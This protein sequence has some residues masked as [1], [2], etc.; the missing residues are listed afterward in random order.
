MTLSVKRA[1]VAALV[2]LV[3]LVGGIVYVKAQ[4]RFGD[5]DSVDYLRQFDA[6]LGTGL[7]ALGRD[8]F[9][10]TVTLE[11]P[12]D[13]PDGERH[14]RVIRHVVSDWA[15]A[16]G[17]GAAV[18]V[19]VNASAAALPRLDDYR[20]GNTTILLLDDLGPAGEHE[21]FGAIAAETSLGANDECLIVFWLIGSA[22]ASE[23]G[24]LIAHELFHCVQIA[25]LS[26]AQMTSAAA[27]GHG[28]GGTWWMEGSADWFSTFALPAAPFIPG[29][30]ATFDRDSPTV[31]LNRMSYEAFVF[32]AW[33]GTT[34][35]PQRMIPFLRRMAGSSD[36][37]AQRAAMRD[38]MTAAE[39]LQFAKDYLDQRIRDGQGASIDSAPAGGDDWTWTDTRT[40]RVT[41]APFVLKRGYANLECGR[42]AFRATP[43]EHH[44]AKPSGAGGAWAPFPATIDA[45]DGRPRQF[46][47]AAMAATD[48]AVALSLAATREAACEE[49]AGSREIDRCLVGTWRMTNSGMAEFANRM[50]GGHARVAGVAPDT[51]MVLRED[52]TFAN[53]TGNA[54]STIVAPKGRADGRMRGTSTGRWSAAGGM[55]NACPDSHATAGT[56]TGS[57]AGTH[58]TMPMPASTARPMR[59]AYTCDGDTL[60]IR[61]DLGRAGSLHNTFERVSPPAEAPRP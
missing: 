46:R 31:P 33:I 37:S 5:C 56:I 44:A 6:R 1:V 34:S 49:C 21:N 30:V 29:R 60:R 26:N 22:D 3:L 23:V 55:L 32:F 8:D 16:P 2:G 19:G 36:E 47:F 18:A 4:D 52:R 14:I 57:G 53:T 17:V 59:N 48:D 11:V 7:G 20:L 25:S 9:Q 50:M 58:G 41:L 38:A 12:V 35:G 40:E 28:G 45:L 42:W 24:G 51:T 10:C 13:T 39:W 27:G 15:E 43:A 61:L 54:T